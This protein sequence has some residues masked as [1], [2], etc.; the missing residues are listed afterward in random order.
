MGTLSTGPISSSRHEHHIRIPQ[1]A[2]HNVTSRALHAQK[3]TETPRARE[4]RE[5]GHLLRQQIDDLIEK[6]N[7]NYCRL[8]ATSGASLLAAVSVFARTESAEWCTRLDRCYQAVR[9]GIYL[10]A[11]D[12]PRHSSAAFWSMFTPHG[13]RFL[14][15][16]GGQCDTVVC[17]CVKSQKMAVGPQN[18]HILI[19]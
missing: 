9:A 17:A 15:V 3:D 18:E 19:G 7:W 12:H 13:A 2:L 14:A 6:P 1:H 4:G 8:S 11:I 16:R 10:L 5:G